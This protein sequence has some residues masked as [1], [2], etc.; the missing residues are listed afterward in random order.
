MKETIKAHLEGVYK[1]YIEYR[2]YY[3][4]IY[5]TP[6][7]RRVEI[8][9]KITTES[10]PQEVI[11]SIFIYNFKYNRYEQDIYN[12]L[13]RLFHTVRA[14]QDLIEIPE[15]LLKEVENFKMIQAYTVKNGEEKEIN[16]EEN[17]QLKVLLKQNYDKIVQEFNTQPT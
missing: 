4:S 13:T 2:D 10:E 11:D 3:K 17:E 1:E 16:K 14:Y 5:K 7:E 9:N 8:A 15:E 6:E 12:L